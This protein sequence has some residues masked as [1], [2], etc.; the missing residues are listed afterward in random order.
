MHYVANFLNVLDDYFLL[1]VHL[2]GYRYKSN[3]VDYMFLCEHL[4]PFQVF[5]FVQQILYDKYFG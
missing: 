3:I 5:W 1:V 4:L 2:F